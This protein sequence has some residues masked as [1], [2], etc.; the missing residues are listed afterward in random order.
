MNRYGGLQPKGSF[1]NWLVFAQSYFGNVFWTLFTALIFAKLARPSRLK[2]TIK[3]SN[4]AVM[5]RDTK[6]FV[7][8]FPDYDDP[9]LNSINSTHSRNVSDLTN[10]VNDDDDDKNESKENT[11]NEMNNDGDDNDDFNELS[12][13]NDEKEENE[14]KNKETRMSKISKDSEIED[15]DAK[16]S[17]YGN[18]EKG[19]LCLVFRFGDMRYRSRICESAFNLICL[20]RKYIVDSNSELNVDYSMTEMD[21]EINEQK[22]RVRSMGTSTPLLSLPWT[23]IHRVDALSPLWGMTKQ[24]MINQN[25]EIIGILDGIDEATSDNFQSWFSYTMDD[26]KF[27]HQFEPMVSS[28]IVKSSLIDNQGN[29]QNTLKEMFQIDYDK[30]SSVVPIHKSSPLQNP[31]KRGSIN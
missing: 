5:N 22:G 26:I 1:A 10:T 21:F 16:W 15:S 6:C 7:P 19:D 29:K 9:S 14:N 23:V 4:Y 17:E 12:N 30:I 27:D 28:N 20:K 3:F 13:L 8:I 2:R 25:I 11:R 31:H 24:D 18:Y